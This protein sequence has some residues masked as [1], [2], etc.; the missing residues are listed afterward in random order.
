MINEDIEKKT[1]ARLKKI[2]GQIKGIQKMITD[3]RYCIDV[4]TQ[5][6]AVESA[7]HTVAEIILRNHLETC[8]RQAF[9]SENIPEREAKISELI[10]VYRSLQK[11]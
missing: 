6:T 7:L 4:I 1:V 11:H 2:E 5:I 8:V 10:T 9:A 3:R